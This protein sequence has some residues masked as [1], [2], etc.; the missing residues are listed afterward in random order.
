MNE[1]VRSRI[2]ELTSANYAQTKLTVTLIAKLCVHEICTF[3]CSFNSWS[4]IY[5]ISKLDRMVVEKHQFSAFFGCV[6][7][8]GL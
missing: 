7:K 3:H 2:R 8:S 4:Q 5:H 1:P 6:F